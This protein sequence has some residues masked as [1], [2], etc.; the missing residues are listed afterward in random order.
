M[1]K[2]QILEKIQDRTKNYSVK[3]TKSDGSERIMNFTLNSDLID[4]FELTPKGTG[5][6]SNQEVLKVVELCENGTTQWRSFRF[7]SVIS[8]DEYNP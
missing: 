4:D 7:D 3:F 1:T 2:D 5:G 8:L 6:N